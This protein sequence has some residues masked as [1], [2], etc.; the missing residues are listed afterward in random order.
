M[1]IQ[2]WTDDSFTPI[3]KFNG[4]FT[5]TLSR[6]GAL[7]GTGRQWVNIGWLP[8]GLSRV[9]SKV[10][11]AVERGLWSQTALVLIPALLPTG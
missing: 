5:T 1:G 3:H 10:F 11:Q 2:E 4:S 7:L 9:A 8:Q 6:Q